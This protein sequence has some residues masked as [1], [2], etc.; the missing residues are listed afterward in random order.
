MA[1][2]GACHGVIEPSW[3]DYAASRGLDA[4]RFRAMYLKNFLM[5]SLPDASQS[6]I[7]WFE[8]QYAG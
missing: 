1:E 2:H 3:L 8:E 7:Q 4:E 6:M 5:G